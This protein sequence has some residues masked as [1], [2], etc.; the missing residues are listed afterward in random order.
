LVTVSF[1]INQIWLISAK[2]ELDYR[3]DDAKACERR[4]WKIERLPIM[5]KI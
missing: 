3:T 5:G 2:Y 4:N 1:E